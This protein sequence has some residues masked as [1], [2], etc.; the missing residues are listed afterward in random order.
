MSDTEEIPRRRILLT[1]EIDADSWEHVERALRQS[2]R[3]LAEKVLSS[4]TLTIE[5]VT[6]GPDYAFSLTANED[7]LITHESYAAALERWR[8]EN[9]GDLGPEDPTPV[10][11]AG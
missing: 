7:P 5:I 1:L 8:I 9:S 4:S 3:D 11:G 10:P 6:S 2:E